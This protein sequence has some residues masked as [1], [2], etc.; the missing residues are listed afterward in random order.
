MNS[1]KIFTK[2]FLLNKTWSASGMRT[3]INKKQGRP[4]EDSE[5]APAKGAKQGKNSLGVGGRGRRC[6]PLQWS[7]GA[8]PRKIDVFEVYNCQKRHFLAGNAGHSRQIDI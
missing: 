8:E 2:C 3:E 5:E 6:T 4:S 7:P 1:N